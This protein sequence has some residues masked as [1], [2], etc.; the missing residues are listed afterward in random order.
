MYMYIL[1]FQT[2]LLK[3]LHC[4]CRNEKKKSQMKFQSFYSSFWFTYIRICPST[5]AAVNSPTQGRRQKL[6][7]DQ[8][9]LPET[10]KKMTSKF[11]DA[12]FL[13]R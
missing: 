5:A 13:G 2:K 6:V 3:T 9:T 1:K 8:T 4:I 10:H 12:K 7:A 11:Y